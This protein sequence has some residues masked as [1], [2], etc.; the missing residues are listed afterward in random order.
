MM[1]G[2]DRSDRKTSKKKLAATGLLHRNERVLEIES[3]STRSHSVEKWLR[4]RL[5]TCLK[6]DSRMNDFQ[7]TNYKG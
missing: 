5:W 4:K 3:G 6:T 2:K 7:T 1:M